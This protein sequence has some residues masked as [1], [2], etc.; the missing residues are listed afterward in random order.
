MR[1][2]ESSLSDILSG[3]GSDEAAQM[4]A[5]ARVGLGRLSNLLSDTA[6]WDRV[7][8]EG[9]RQRLALARIHLSQPDIVLIED[10]LHALDEADAAALYADLRASLP[11]AMI[12]TAGSSAV[13]AAAADTGLGSAGA[14][15]LAAPTGQDILTLQPRRARRKPV[16]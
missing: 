15:V 1:W 8:T 14:P 7:L 13:L 5:L 10:A 12:V 3:P 4:A 2:A 9:E 6:D 16:A 11:K